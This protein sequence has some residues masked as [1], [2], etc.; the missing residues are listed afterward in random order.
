MHAEM[1][2]ITTA[3]RN[4]IAISGATLA[5]TT[6]PCHNCTRHLIAAGLCRVVYIH[7]YSKSLARDLH[8]DAIV[9]EPEDPA[10]HAD[11]VV[12]E[13]YLGVAPRV[14]PQYFSFD[15]VDRKDPRGRAQ[16]SPT[17]G[18]A[19][20]RVLENSGSFSFGGPA[21]PLERTIEL[22]Q[23]FVKGFEELIALKKLQ[24]PSPTQPE[25]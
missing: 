23:T 9:I 3:A 11:K 15:L 6:F 17:P 5:T 10:A 20:P 16:Q 24:L 4:G 14:F 18:D 13:Q 25:V 21:F 8:D 2:A 12:L 22:E 7:P 1:D 19:L